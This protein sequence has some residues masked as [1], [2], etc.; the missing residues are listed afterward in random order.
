MGSDMVIAMKEASATGTTLFGLNH[1]APATRQYRVKQVRAQFHDLGEKIGTAALQLPQ[2]RQT[3]AVLGMQPVGQ[4]GFAHGVNEHHVVA[5]ATGWQSRLA[6]DG[7][8][9]SGFELVR[10]T[11]ERSHS[12][13]HAVDVLADLIG[14]HGQ[15]STQNDGRHD[16]IFMIA[17]RDEAFVLEASGRYW[18]LMECRHTRVATDTAMIR[19]DW[20]KFAPG[21][22]DQVIQ[23][24]WWLDD[25]SKIDFVRC[26]GENTERAFHAQ[27]R[28]GRASLALAQQQ[29][30]IDLHFLRHMLAEH[31]ENNLDLLSNTPEITLANTF[32]VDLQKEEVP[33]LAWISCGAPNIGLHFPLCLCG[34]L[35]PAWAGGHP[36][37]PTIE[38]HARELE[39]L[40]RDDASQ[41]SKIQQMLERLQVRFDQDA[42]EFLIKGYE[43]NLRH[44]SNL[45]S[46]LATEMMHNHVDLFGKEYRRL[47]D[48]KEIAIPPADE[49]EEV[50]FFA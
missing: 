29:G 42:E 36:E 40:A 26:L 4:W 2:V 24:G 30:A 1:H 14:R 48:V 22:A 39:N 49:T 6:S 33:V 5:G 32:L 9:L 44:N 16:H 31:Y 50:V 12:A 35:P 18:A 43:C 15:G 41:R 46:Q 47:L 28:W 17:D 45:L 27:K 23:Q 10:L 3:A 21:L 8:T 37:N 13:L 19:Q 25:G 20:C 7:Q 11:L 38:Q 34:E